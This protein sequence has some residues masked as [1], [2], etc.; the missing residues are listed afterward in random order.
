MKNP[1]Y[2]EYHDS[3]WGVLCTDDRKLFE[4]LVL[5]GFQAGLS[6]ECVLNKR[7]AFEKA[8]DGFDAEKVAKY[9][10]DKIAELMQNE[11]IIRNKLK[12]RASVSNAAA[13][14]NISREFG[15]FYEYLCTF[16]GK[17]TVYE[18]GRANS[19][20]SDAISKDLKKRG[21]KFVGTTVIYSFLQAVG[22]IN[23]H[24]KQC[25]KYAVTKARIKKSEQP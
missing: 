11:G 15:S 13:F 24:E 23:S 25:F 14:I 19:P 6:W 1:L 21:M 10:E 2:I 8:F 7:K 20:L 17:N 4:M 12:I 18:C 16:S 5:E 22:I 9:G 3:E